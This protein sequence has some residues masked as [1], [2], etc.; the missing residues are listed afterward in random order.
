[1]EFFSMEID[2]LTLVSGLEWQALM[3]GSSAAREKNSLGKE[4]G[5]TRL[6]EM[7][8]AHETLVGFLPAVASG[9]DLPKKIYSLAAMLAGV[10]N[11]S[12]YCVLVIEDGDVAIL[13]ALQDGLPSPGFD[14]YGPTE[15]IIAAAREFINMA[16]QGVTVYGNCK[17][18]DATP[19][20]LERIVQ[21]TKTKSQALVRSLPKPAYK[22]G[23]LAL[24]AIIFAATANYAYD[25]KKKQELAELAKLSYV[26]VDAKYLEN[27]SALLKAAPPAKAVFAMLKDALGHTETTNNGW[28]LSTILCDK[29][30]CIYNW[31]NDGGTNRS[32]V[33]PEKATQVVFADKGDALAYRIAYAQPLP[34]GLIPAQAQE[35]DFIKKETVGQF[36]ELVDMKVSS[37]FEKVDTFGVPSG[38]P[39]SPTKTYKEGAFTVIG[40]WYAMEVLENL[41]DVTAFESLELS[42]GTD[43]QLSFKA[44]GKY[45][46]K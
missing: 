33:P 42:V 12:P 14:G 39:G 41:P 8:N 6:V 15:N 17:L 7:S 36:Q 35:L 40:P 20:A 1:M 5:S 16:P 37:A 10:P 9:A 31:A 27:V 44:T 22:F 32:F 23:M 28:A 30:G 46:V 26:N 13:A 24:L 4:L 11:I 38:L 29:A 18:M 43:Q 19:L 3:G 2:E 34:S 45:Y 25:Y 21:T